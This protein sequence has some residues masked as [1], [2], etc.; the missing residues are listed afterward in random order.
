VITVN[1]RFIIVGIA[2]GIIIAIAVYVGSPMF[3]GYDMYR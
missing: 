3:L 2:L 1:K